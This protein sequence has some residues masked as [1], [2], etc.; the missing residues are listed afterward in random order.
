MNTKFKLRNGKKNNTILLDFRFGREIRVR[1]STNLI[2]KK[3]SEKYW[4]NSKG[5]IKLPNNISNYA[6]INNCLRDYEES[7]E[8]AMVSLIKENKLTQANCTKAIKK[9]LNVFEKDEDTDKSDS[10]IVLE[11]FEWFLGYYSLHNSPFTKK[12]L[13]NGTLKTYTNC[14]NFLSNYLK[15]KKINAFRFE[16]IDEDFYND[17]VNYGKIKKYSRNYMGTNIQKLKTIIGYAFENKVHSNDAFKKRYFAKLKEEINHPYLDEKELALIYN[18]K[19]DDEL[20]RNVRDIFL[21]AS[22]TGL[23]V[24]DLSDFLSSPKLIM[25]NGK[26]FIHL[27]QNKTEGE[28][29]IPINSIIK[30]IL[31]I[32]DGKFPPYVHPNIINK[33]IKC[34]A[35]KAKINDDF[36]IERTI[37]DSKVKI[38]KPKH[39]FITAHTARRSFCTNAYNSGMAPHQI[40][41]ISGHKSEK[42]FYSYIKASVKR[43]AL[44]AAEHSFFN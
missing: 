30:N 20:M 36:I 2:I 41:V 25:I 3:A 17:F 42:V 16:D 27:I 40:M 35:R 11:Y 4:D 38:V 39:K 7:I 22:Y 9:A 19:L 14:K 23:R 10:N 44:Q 29:Y 28:V 24:G 26:E 31:Q 32:R 33:L 13:K 15:Y 34:I 37:S 12:P 6:F 5:R 43:K 8:K 1:I 21:I 18:L